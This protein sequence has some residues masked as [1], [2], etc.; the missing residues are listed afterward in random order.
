MKKLL[1]I[2][3]FFFLFTSISY[4][5]T[6]WYKY[7]DNPIISGTS[8]TWDAAYVAFSAVIHDTVYKMWYTG[9]LNYGSFADSKIGYATS[10]DGIN[11]D[12]RPEPVLTKGEA[13]K[14]DE[15]T[16]A[17]ASVIYD[18]GIYKMWYIGTH[19]GFTNNWRIGY[20]TSPDG[21]NWTRQNDGNPVLNLGAAGEWDDTYVGHVSVIR[22][23]SQLKMWYRGSRLPG[24]ADGSIGLA[25]STDGINWTKYDDPLTT[26]P[27]YAGSD[28]VLVPTPGRW[29][30][31]VVYHPNVILNDSTYEMW[32]VA[33]GNMIGQ[34]V[35]YATSSDGINWDKDT[36]NPVMEIGS[37]GSFDDFRLLTPCIILEN[38]IYK[39][40]YTGSDNIT[41]RIG[42]ASTDP[43]AVSIE[44]ESFSVPEVF[45]LGQNYPNP[46]NPSTVISYQLPVSTHVTLVV[47]DILGK[48]NTILVNEYKPAGRHEVTFDV[49]HLA[50]GVYI[51]RLQAGEYVESRKML[52]LK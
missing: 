14:F 27:P 36:S 32:Y 33:M 29:D 26:D 47:H 43:S 22:D 20:A 5:Q 10:I 2:S 4:S 17:G 8:G 38:D 30:S 51:Y 19:S 21:I 24:G 6:E 7:P 16:V 44:L 39:M 1:Q 49:S 34:N 28:P 3:L 35:G 42:Y 31:Q 23:G 52:Y 25:T 37:A 15:G 11:W 41:W 46:F 9:G 12:K 48:D 13:G 18:E 50:S 40:W 45:S